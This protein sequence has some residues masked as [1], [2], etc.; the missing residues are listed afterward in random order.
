MTTYLSDTV[1]QC[2]AKAVSVGSSQLMAM[3]SSTANNVVLVVAA[4]A[5][6]AVLASVFVATK[7]E[8]VISMEDGYA[9]L[10]D[11]VN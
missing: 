8:R 7:A 5:S 9:S 1:T 6:V 2:S 4:V 3:Y 11:D 10:A